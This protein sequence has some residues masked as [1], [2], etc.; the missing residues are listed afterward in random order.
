MRESLR[1]F[2]CS[3]DEPCSDHVTLSRYYSGIQALLQHLDLTM[4]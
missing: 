2:Y 4:P 1:D 3:L